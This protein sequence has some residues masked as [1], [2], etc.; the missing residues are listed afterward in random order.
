MQ[1]VPVRTCLLALDKFVLQHGTAGDPR[2]RVQRHAALGYRLQ[3]L[4]RLDVFATFGADQRLVARLFRLR[5]ACLRLLLTEA[6]FFEECVGDL[7][8]VKQFLTEYR[9][10]I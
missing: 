3:L 1:Q 9:A 5:L 6:D 10:K 2:R 8:A 7:R 4:L